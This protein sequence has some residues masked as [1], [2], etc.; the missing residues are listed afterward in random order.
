MIQ[1]ALELRMKKVQDVMTPIDN[2]Y[3]VDI[4][5]TLDFKVALK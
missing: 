3:M 4:S 2:C 5:R 1:G